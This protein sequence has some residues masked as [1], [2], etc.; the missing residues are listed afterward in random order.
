MNI[1][2]G[3]DHLGIDLNDEAD[4]ET[5]GRAL[6]DVVSPGVVIGLVG[7]LGAGKTRLVRALAE[8]LEVD[9]DAIASPTFV[10]IH[11]YEGTMPVYHFDVYRLPSPAAFEDLGPADYWSAGG[12]CLVEWA[13]RVPDSLPPDAWWITLQAVDPTRR[14]VRITAPPSVRERLA[15]LLEAAPH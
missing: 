8:A 7:N 1:R 3:D 5:L 12:V 11:E 15:A 6:A 9:P 14:T 2:N 4:T 13:D 10:L